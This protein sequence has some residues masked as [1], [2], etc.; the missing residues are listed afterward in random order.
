MKH[1]LFRPKDAG[2]PGE[3][4]VASSPSLRDKAGIF[5]AG[6]GEILR[7]PLL[8]KWAEKCKFQPDSRKPGVTDPSLSCYVLGLAD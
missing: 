6:F 2:I 1:H 7:S 8:I 5:D 4:P 3:L